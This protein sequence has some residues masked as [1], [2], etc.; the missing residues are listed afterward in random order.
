[1]ASPDWPSPYDGEDPAAA[2]LADSVS[3]RAVHPGAAHTRLNR[4]RHESVA[5]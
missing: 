3:D 1:M 2:R 4:R 5:P